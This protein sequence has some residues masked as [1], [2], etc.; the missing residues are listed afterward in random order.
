MR[1]FLA[2]YAETA[3][4]TEAAEAAGIHRDTHYGWLQRYPEYR[5][6]F[7][8]AHE[9]ACDR[10]EAEVRRRGVE[11]WLE[12]RFDRDGNEVGAIR[13]YSDNL[14]MFH[15]KSLRPERYRDNAPLPARP[16]PDIA[17]R[18]SSLDADQLDA[19]CDAIKRGERPQLPEPG[20][21]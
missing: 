11:G 4:V 21:A 17:R 18:L 19:L 15:M 7:L 2:A 6:A 9:A 14:L 20:E 1:G 10:V 8:E 16:G 5:E 3:N 12:P 13:R